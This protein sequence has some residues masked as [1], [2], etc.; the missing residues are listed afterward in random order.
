M[1]SVRAVIDEARALLR[2]RLDELDEEQRRLE[3]ALAELNG[4]ATRRG[5]GRR[6]GSKG[7]AGTAGKT[8]RRRRQGGR[9]EQAVQL[10]EKRPGITASDVAKAMK[11]KPNYLYRVLGELE[12]AGRVKKQGRK[13]HPVS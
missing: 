1:P 2:K 11:I 10:I 3:R 6:R 9:A 5:P 12:K 7:S 13:Y 4:K 8:P